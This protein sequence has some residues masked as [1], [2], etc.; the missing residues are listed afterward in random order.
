MD[1]LL[2]CIAEIILQVFAE[3]VFSF[4]IYNPKVKNRVKTLIFSVMAHTITALFICGTVAL[5]RERNSAWY[6]LAVLSAVWGIGM[7]IAAIYGHKKGWPKN[8]I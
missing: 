8:E 2:E 5:F 1:F 6:V 3:G 7:L 4:S